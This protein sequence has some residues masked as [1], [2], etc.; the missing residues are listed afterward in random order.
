MP[1]TSS[2]IEYSEIYVSRRL[3]IHSAKVIFN[4][5]WCGEWAPA[6][7]RLPK[8]HKR[9]ANTTTIKKT[10][11]ELWSQ[12]SM[13]AYPWQAHEA[14]KRQTTIIKETLH[15]NFEHSTQT[16]FLGVFFFIFFF[17]F[18]FKFVSIL[19]C[20][21]VAV[22]FFVCYSVVVRIKYTRENQQINTC[23]ACGQAVT[24]LFYI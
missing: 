7:T 15:Y 13:H 18:F 23:V 24:L 3:N 1:L 4:F 8:R 21:V 12:R 22:L 9:A 2:V 16:L 14:N 20:A 5:V 6:R 17:F 19:L 10:T 11:Q